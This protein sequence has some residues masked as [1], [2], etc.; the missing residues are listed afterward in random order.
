MKRLLV[1]ALFAYS[2]QPDYG[3]LQPEYEQLMEV[4][5]SLRVGKA[6]RANIHKRV[7]SL[8]AEVDAFVKQVDE[9]ERSMNA[10]V[11][12]Y[13][14]VVRMETEWNNTATKVVEREINE[15]RRLRAQQRNR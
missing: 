15:N 6:N 10:N 4:K 13:K 11:R 5:D 9:Y 1:L 8:Q 2:C 12:G 14:R 3:Y 7:D